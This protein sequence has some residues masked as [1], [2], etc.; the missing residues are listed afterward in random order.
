MQSIAARRPKRR[1][2]AKPVEKPPV[3]VEP[4][5]VEE[6]RYL[7]IAMANSIKSAAQHPSC[8]QASPSK[9]HVFYPTMEEFSQ[10]MK[11]I[12]R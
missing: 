1:K 2:I 7:K 8:F 11:Y 3:V 10:P 12:H 5:T 4:M 6:K 9:A